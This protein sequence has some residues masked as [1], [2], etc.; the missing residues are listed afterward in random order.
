MEAELQDPEAAAWAQSFAPGFFLVP[1]A[2][3]LAALAT[4]SRW[5]TSKNYTQAA[6][7]T[8]FQVADYYLVAQA[9]ADGHTVVTHEVPS[10]SLNQ[11]KIPNA[12]LEFGLRCINTYEM[13]RREKARFVL[14]K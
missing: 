11:I 10:A 7:T 3:V 13:L 1:D 12:C 14:A 4:V 2:K 8:F 5:A 9:L 6:I